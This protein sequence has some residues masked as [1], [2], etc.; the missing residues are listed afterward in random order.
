MRPSESS[1]NSFSILVTVGVGW[2][3]LIS[4]RHITM[5]VDECVRLE[6]CIHGWWSRRHFLILADGFC[7]RLFCDNIMVDLRLLETVLSPC[8]GHSLVFV[9]HSLLLSASSFSV[10]VEG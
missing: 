5:S 6:T 1:Y 10:F 8:A 9:C 7:C 2:S 3:S 4:L